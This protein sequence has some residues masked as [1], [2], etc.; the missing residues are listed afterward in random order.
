MILEVEDQGRIERI[1]IIGG[2]EEK[3]VDDR[4]LIGGYRPAN[5]VY[6]EI[7]FDKALW[8]STLIYEGKYVTGYRLT[9]KAS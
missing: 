3:V 8:E 4:R 9:R 7:W 2:A 6:D 5:G 1:A